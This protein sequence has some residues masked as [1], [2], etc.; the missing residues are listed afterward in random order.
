MLFIL[1]KFAEKM[2]PTLLD[3]GKYNEITV[4][5]KSKGLITNLE[6]ILEID[7]N[8]ATKYSLKTRGCSL[9]AEEQ[10]TRALNIAFHMQHSEKDTYK[11]EVL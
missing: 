8:T 2:D 7:S 5:G 1:V 3:I 10:E 6:I 11:D 4:E 9:S